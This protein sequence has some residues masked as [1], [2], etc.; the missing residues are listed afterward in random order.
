MNKR[1]KEIRAL[2]EE[3]LTLGRRYEDYLKC[4]KS[5]KK[6]IIRRIRRANSPLYK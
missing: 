5:E 3:P 2:T 4:E 1:L 6:S